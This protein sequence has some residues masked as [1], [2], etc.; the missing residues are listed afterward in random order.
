M[1]VTKGRDMGVRKTRVTQV[2][3]SSAYATKPSIVPQIQK[4]KELY[5][6]A[7]TAAN[8]NAN[9]NAGEAASVQIETPT[10]TTN[11]NV[12]RTPSRMKLA[13]TFSLGAALGAAGFW[14]F[15]RYFGVDTAVV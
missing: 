13:G 10:G 8:T 14:A 3:P 9:A 12:S 11:I 4:P 6:N 1:A 2:T 5:M 15:K 7:D